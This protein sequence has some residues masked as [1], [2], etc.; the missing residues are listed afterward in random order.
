[1]ATF[2]KSFDMFQKTLII[3]PEGSGKT[4]LLAMYANGYFPTTYIPTIE[5]KNKIKTIE[6]SNGQKCKLNMWDTPGQERLRHKTNTLF[7]DDIV[8]VVLVALDDSEW[9]QSIHTFIDH[10]KKQGPPD[11]M[12]IA[13]VGNK[14]DADRMVT[15]EE[16]SKAVEGFGLPYYEVSSK[17]GENV[18]G[19][20]FSIVDH[21]N[22]FKSWN[23]KAKMFGNKK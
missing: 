13:V 6:L 19:T 9:K 16:I 18:H 23:D 17:T 2:G 10:A 20:F 12:K 8:V 14:K 7:G 21:A 22:V 3:G 11:K 15:F 1:M 5:I 4:S